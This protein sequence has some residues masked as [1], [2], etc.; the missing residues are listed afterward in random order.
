M[1]MYDV[2]MYEHNDVHVQDEFICN[3]YMCEHNDVHV[4]WMNVYVQCVHV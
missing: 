3:V 1:N 2:Y 4:Q